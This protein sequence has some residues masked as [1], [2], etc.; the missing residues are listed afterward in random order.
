[1]G[2]QYC[3]I[4]PYKESCAKTEVEETD[5]PHNNTLYKAVKKLRDQGI[6]VS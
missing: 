3:L 2:D 5:F 6:K 1:M 4:G